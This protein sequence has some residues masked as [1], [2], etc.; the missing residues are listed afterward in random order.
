MGVDFSSSHRA[1]DVKQH[2]ET[3]SAFIKLVVG[4][5][6]LCIVILVGMALFL[7]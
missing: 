5:G 7:T 4:V 2:E 1:M 3:Y 6:A